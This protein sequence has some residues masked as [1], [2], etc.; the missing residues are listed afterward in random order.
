MFHSFTCVE[1]HCFRLDNSCFDLLY[2][3]GRRRFELANLLLWDPQKWLVCL[4]FFL[5][6]LELASCK[7]ESVNVWWDY[8]LECLRVE[9]ELR[10][11]CF[12]WLYDVREDSQ[13][14]SLLFLDNG[15]SDLQVFW[16]DCAVMVV[17]LSGSINCTSAFVNLQGM[18][19]LFYQF[20]SF[21]VHIILVDV[22]VESAVF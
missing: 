5:H 20:V 11:R 6:L 1:W 12:L 18:E 14:R 19:H 15:L 21:F 16:L 4:P 9:D 17:K 8:S 7:A 22:Y 13:T 3:W 10:L 2:L